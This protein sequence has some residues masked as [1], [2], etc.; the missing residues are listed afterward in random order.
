M[1]EAQDGSRGRLG[2]GQAEVDSRAQWEAEMS[3]TNI[4]VMGTEEYTVRVNGSEQVVNLPNLPERD[5]A[6][7]GHG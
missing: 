2:Q 3:V 7:G 4:G 5:C 1:Y 6:V